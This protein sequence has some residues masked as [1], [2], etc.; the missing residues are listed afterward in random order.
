MVIGDLFGDVALQWSHA[1]E[2][3]PT[4]TSYVAD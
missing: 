3:A 4:S 1:G 2:Y